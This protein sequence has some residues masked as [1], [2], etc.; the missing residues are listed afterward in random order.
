MHFFNLLGG[1]HEYFGKKIFKPK[2]IHEV[3]NKNKLK[4][5]A[6]TIG[7]ER[8]SGGRSGGPRA[9][10]GQQVVSIFFALHEYHFGLKIFLPKYS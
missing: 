10:P 2:W 6:D 8:W 5:L 4:P 3:R 1:I 7:P 9:Q